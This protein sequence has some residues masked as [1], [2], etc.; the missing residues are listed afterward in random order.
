[1]GSFFNKAKYEQTFSSINPLEGVGTAIGDWFAGSKEQEAELNRKTQEALDYIN[2]LQI[3]KRITKEDWM[4]RY[5][6]IMDAKLD[7]MRRLNIGENPSL[8]DWWN[9]RVKEPI[10]DAVIDMPARKQAM[11][12]ASSTAEAARQVY[13]RSAK[14]PADLNRLNKATNDAFRVASAKIDNSGI[15]APVIHGVEKVETW[16][17]EKQSTVK[18]VLIAGGVLVALWVVR[19]ILVA[20]LGRSRD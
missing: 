20:M 4:S 19:P 18:W 6:Q 14:T 3:S 1:M 7:Y 9:L 16:W 8:S 12:D 15:A 13:L 2:Q 11:N 5:T 17:D 10:L